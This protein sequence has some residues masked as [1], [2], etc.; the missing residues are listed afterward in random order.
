MTSCLSE[1][2]LDNI[3]KDANNRVTVSAPQAEQGATISV[4]R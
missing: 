1:E 2:Q 3:V 4:T